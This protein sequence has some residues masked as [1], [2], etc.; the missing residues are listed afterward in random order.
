MK[1]SPETRPRAAID[2]LGSLH[3]LMLSIEISKTSW[4][5][6]NSKTLNEF[7]MAP[8]SL[9]ITTT[10]ES[11]EPTTTAFPFGSASIETHGVTTPLSPE[12]ASIL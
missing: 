12:L 2:R 9:L 10:C 3:Q 4:P 6:C 1:T 7:W 5:S 8:V 11:L